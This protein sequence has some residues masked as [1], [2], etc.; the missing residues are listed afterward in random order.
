M[1]DLQQ[2]KNE[3]RIMFSVIA[4]SQSYGTNTPESDIDLRGIFRIPNGD[5]LTLNN[6]TKQVAYREK[7][8]PINLYGHES[9]DVTFYELRRYFELASDCNPNIIELLWTP[10]DCIEH[11]D[12]IMD[13]LLANRHLFIS[14]K[15]FHTF[16]GYAHAQ[17]KRAKGQNKWVNNPKPKE[18][19]KREDFCWFVPIPLPLR[20]SFDSTVMPYRPM[21]LEE[22]NIDLSQH[23]AAKMEHLENAFRIYNYGD[24]A[25]GVFRNGN[26]ALESIPK[27]DENLR[28][29]GLLIYN[30]QAYLKAKQDHTNY[31][32][33]KR[34]RNEARYRT[35][36]SGELDY[37]C[38]LE[39]ETEFLTD[40]GWLTYDEITSEDML[41]TVNPNGNYFE[42][43]NHY[44]R[45]SSEY[46]GKV[47]TYENSYSR[48]SVTP[49]HNI[50]VSN[51]SRGPKN[52][53]SCKYN[54][55][56]ANW[57]L[58]TV[59]D[60][61]NGRRSYKHILTCCENQPFDDAN[62][63]DDFIKLLG[64]YV[65]E[66]SIAYSKNGNPKYIYISQLEGGKACYLMDGLTEFNIAVS[67]HFRKG[68]NELTYIIKDDCLAEKFAKYGGNSQDKELPFELVMSFS[69]RQCELLVE[70][71]MSG[72]GHKHEKGHS[73]YYTSS[74]KLADDLFAMLIKNGIPCQLYGPYQ[75]E[76]ELPMYQVFI[77][78]F[79]KQD[80]TIM[81]NKMEVREEGYSGW[82]NKHVENERIVCF[83]V[84]NKILITR[85]KGKVAIQGNSKNL[86]H[87]M[88]LLESGRHI[89]ET[90]EPLVRFSGDKLQYLR[91]V[92]AGKFTYEEL[93]QSIEDQMED[94]KTVRDK[95]ELPEKV[96]MKQINKLYEELVHI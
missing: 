12:P 68:R 13:V 48:F 40:S 28:I 31:W 82:S 72:D 57:H 45:H 6:P 30:K 19:P 23:H 79:R 91:D 18:G 78:N 27:E 5:F 25:K 32:E 3:G 75:Y 4:G 38:Y 20:L 94:L 81:M 11:K 2:L 26:I 46:T 64:L 87:C 58:E 39:S 70:S 8:K 55:E 83:S 77:S 35:Q 36:E 85:N 89:L 65:S 16:S 37:D 43:Q 84:L 14:K 93:M 92:R 49:N 67:K 52:G 29:S 42:F 74:N 63:S 50:Y 9:D 88:R 66:G 61:W 90:G 59:E 15:A 17:I 69:K 41:A 44:D 73:V 62:V 71:M 47:Y 80:P 10:E 24:N 51:G 95:S 22:T 34:N 33:W 21:K 53:Y 96:N 54:K 1:S 76:D 56:T 60:Y 86:M 7:D